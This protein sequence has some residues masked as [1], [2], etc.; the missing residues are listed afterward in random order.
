[1]THKVPPSATT[2]V[3]GT[4]PTPKLQSQGPQRPHRGLDRKQPPYPSLHRI[5]TQ[6]NR[7]GGFLSVRAQGHP[8]RNWTTPTATA[9]P[10]PPLT[11]PVRG[12]RPHLDSC[13]KSANSL[14]L[15]SEQGV[16][17]CTTQNN[18]AGKSP[19]RVPL[20]GLASAPSAAFLE[21]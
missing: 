7:I 18:P 4:Q 14:M 11:W 6:E 21:P 20:Q 17:G 3:S 10:Q 8:P 1:M 2:T 5:N 16:P 15:T 12:R 19:N 9:G 13:P